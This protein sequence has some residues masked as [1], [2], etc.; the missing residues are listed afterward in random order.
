VSRCRDVVE[1]VARALADRPDA[2]RV[3]EREHKGQT[4]VELFMAPGDLGRVIGRQGRTATAMRALVAAT[5]DL[6]G[7]KVTLEFRDD[8]PKAGGRGL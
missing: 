3:T 2:V 8:E 6:E 5:A 7:T 4:L 1:V